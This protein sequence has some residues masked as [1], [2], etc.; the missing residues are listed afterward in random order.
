MWA[1]AA[2]AA[3]GLAWKAMPKDAASSMGMS[4]AP[5]PTARVAFVG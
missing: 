4:L 3:L 2:V 1:L 5:S